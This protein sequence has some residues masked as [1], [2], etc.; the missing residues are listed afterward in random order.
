[1]RA[2]FIYGMARTKII[3]HK[4]QAELELMRAANLVVSKALAY[5]G[6]ILRPGIT[7]F[8]LDR[9]AEEFIR[10]HGAVP[11]FKGL[12]GCPS[13]ILTSVN[14]CVVHGLPTA[15]EYRETDL[16]SIDVGAYLGGF[17]GDSAYTYAFRGVDEESMDVLEATNQALYVGIDKARVGN[18]VGEVSY[19]IQRFIERECG[20]AIV[21]ELSGHGIGREFHEAPEVPNFGKRSDGAIMKPGLVIAI[22]PMV[23]TRT[24]HIKTAADGWTI[25]AKDGLATAHFEHSVAVT[26]EGPRTLSDHSFVE[27]AVTN[28]EYLHDPVASE[29]LEEEV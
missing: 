21:R 14:D 1:M 8:E 23:N 2:R 25:L 13:S 20:Y 19:A 27:E 16:V 11:S 10:D 22:E 3:Y 6:T 4:T 17:H 18:R 5:L 9:K 26:R 12:Y 29:I 24:R 15:R 28:N 7:G